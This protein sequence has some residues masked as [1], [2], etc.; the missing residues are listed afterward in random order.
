MLMLFGKM[1]SCKK[2]DVPWKKGLQLRRDFPKASFTGGVEARL[3][4]F[5]DGLAE[6]LKARVGRN[7]WGMIGGLR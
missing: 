2:C 1:V 7:I 5:A 6:A 3:G 4:D